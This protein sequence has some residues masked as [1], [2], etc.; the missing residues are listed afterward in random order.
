MKRFI[1]IA[2]LLIIGTAGQVQAQITS[3][4]CDSMS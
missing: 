4:G 3:V 1:L 2:M